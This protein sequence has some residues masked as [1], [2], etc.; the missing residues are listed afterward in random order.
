MTF[1]QEILRVIPSDFFMISSSSDHQVSEETYNTGNFEL[2]NPAGK[3]GGACTSAFL[4]Q[5]YEGG[6]GKS[7]VDTL[8]QMRG[9]LK[10]MG[11]DQIPTL[12]SSRLIEP[13]APMY[14]VPPG[15]GRRRAL[16]IGINY[17]GQKGELKAC[18]NDCNNIREYLINVHGF[19][20]EEMMI[21]MDDGRHPMPTKKNMED[22][23]ILLTKYSQPGDVVFVSFSGHGGR[24]EDLN[25][26]ED[27]GWDETYV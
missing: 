12:S 7:W 18:H 13:D 9:V 25:Q 10:G 2:P 27:D 24:T 5:Q 8:Q 4:Q 22:G 14:I 19:R 3:A 26:D 15:S 6:K 21:L 20:E 17:V 23:F 16:L 1:D 11:Y